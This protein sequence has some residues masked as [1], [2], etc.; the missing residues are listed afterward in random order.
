MTFESTPVPSE[1]VQSEPRRP[2][3]DTTRLTAGITIITLGVLLLA[4]R[5]ARPDWLERSGWWP[6]FVIAFGIMRIGMCGVR[7]L[8]SG[9]MF[10]LI[11]VWGLL[12]EFEV[13]HYESSW[14]LLFVA[15]GASLVLGGLPFTRQVEAAPATPQ[16]ASDR[17]ARNGEMRFVWMIVF[18]ALLFG[19]VHS[20]PRGARDRNSVDSAGTLRR[21]AVMAQNRT[22][23]YA[24][25]F[26]SARVTALMGECDLDLTH[27]EIRE[28][29]VPVVHVAVTMGQAILRVPQ[30]WI[31]DNQ[32]V[33]LMGDVTD[34]RSRERTDPAEG[35]ADSPRK[36]VVVQGSVV[37]GQ[38]TIR[39]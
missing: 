26:Q 32:I 10:I 6:L 35:A 38:L 28:A 15:M 39:N 2:R 9:L 4:A 25:P 30:D 34:A 16:Q 31:V 12:N 36:R 21:S 11:G 5:T 13:L 22:V 29:D 24:D 37:M 8:S 7:R 17:Q 23:S 20:I 1:P 3:A 33:P 14:P 27:V 18:F 19:G